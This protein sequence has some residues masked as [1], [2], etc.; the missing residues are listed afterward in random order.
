MSILFALAAVLG[1][2][3]LLAKAADAFVDGAAALAVRFAVPTVVIGAI[4]VGLGTSAPELVVS[5]FAAAEGSPEIAVGNVIGSN[6][7][8]LTLVLGAA[9]I[10]AG[11]AASRR[12]VTVE[13]PLAIAATAAFAWAVQNG[14][15]TVEAGVL[16]LV[17]AAALVVMLSASPDEEEELAL[18]EHLVETAPEVVRVAPDVTHHLRGLIKVRAA[19]AHTIAGLVGVLI[20][21][22]LLVTGARSLADTFGL[23]EGLVGLTLVAI[24]TSAPELATAVAAARRGHGSLVIGNVLGSNIFNSVAVGAAT[25]LV[26]AEGLTDASLTVNA[27]VVMCVATVVVAGLLIWRRHLARPAGIG[28]IVLWVASLPLVA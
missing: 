13:L 22:Q 24:G 26:G 7:A 10:L 20:G 21:A 2:L 12:V 15:S 27:V 19:I 17:L 9:G 23:A 6:I 8:N 16:A 5:I 28:L 3:A 11:V 1:G 14:L 25:G 18:A 4:V